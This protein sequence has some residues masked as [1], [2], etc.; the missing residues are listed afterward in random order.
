MQNCLSD[1]NICP[2]QLNLVVEFAIHR[3]EC[4]VAGYGLWETE[5]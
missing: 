5:L 4:S 1:E 2:P 3:G